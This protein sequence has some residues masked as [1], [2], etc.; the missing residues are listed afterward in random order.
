MRR[1]GDECSAL[2]A[3]GREE[4][5]MR[6][7]K[8]QRSVA[9]HGNSAD[10]AACA[11]G[12]YSVFAFDVRQKLLQKKIAVTHGTI[13]GV[14]VKTASAFG[15]DDEKIAHLALVTQIFEQG[16]ATAVEE[17]LLVVAEAV[18][19]IE[20][21]ITLCWMLCGARIVFSGQID[22]IVNHLLE[23]MAFQSAA[24]DPA[25]RGRR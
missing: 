4:F 17:G 23:D 11:A 1:F 16:P 6:E 10:G 19:K 8:A 18:Q 5:R 7:G 20:H 3:G 22:A 12:T 2:G 24:V 13:G 21:R 25:L 9:A 15:S 14:D